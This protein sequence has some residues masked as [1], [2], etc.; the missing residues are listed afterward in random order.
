[1]LRKT[2]WVENLFPFHLTSALIRPKNK[3][4]Y[5]PYVFS[6]EPFTM[7]IPRIQA[8]ID[9]IVWFNGA[10]PLLW[11]S[12]VFLGLASKGIEMQHLTKHRLDLARQ[13][14]IDETN[15]R[16]RDRR[17][18]GVPIATSLDG[19]DKP[20]QE[21]V[22]RKL[23]RLRELRKNHPYNS[24]TDA[25]SITH[26]AKEIGMTG[27]AMQVK[28]QEMRS[29]LKALGYNADDAKKFTLKKLN[30][31]VSDAESFSEVLTNATRN[32]PEGADR[33]LLKNISDAL[34][35]EHGEVEVVKQE[36]DNCNNNGHTE[37][38]KMTTATAVATAPKKK[39]TPQKKSGEKRETRKGSLIDAAI[40]VMKSKPSKKGWKGMELWEAI[41]QKGL[42]TSK[43]GKTPW[44]TLTASIYME[45]KRAEQDGK[46]SRFVK[47]G[48]GFTLKH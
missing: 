18:L 32:D 2:A 25:E 7:S 17:C 34:A 31:M 24:S 20:D 12:V 1:M 42:W 22:I 47:T 48:E 4:G 39:A 6:K 8:I 23:M 40:Q 45:I 46:E 19:N 30:R 16:L 10:D 36:S 41:V 14:A 15:R 28:E 5:N 13:N 38:D 35:E 21:A 26:P 33:D 27:A 9:E 37:E 29:A 43:T 3:G 11:P 44:A